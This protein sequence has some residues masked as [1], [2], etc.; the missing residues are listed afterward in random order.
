MN[1]PFDEA[2]VRHLLEVADQAARTGAGVVARAFNRPRTG[3]RAKGAGDYVTSVDRDSE[4]AIRAHLAKAVPNVA[5]VA[6]EG[7]GERGDLYWAVDPLDGTTN[8][9]IGFPAVAVAVALVSG[10][11]VMV[12]AV[13]APLLDLQFTAARGLGAWSGSS[14]LRVSERPPERAILAMALPFR[15]RE[16]T[17]RYTR[18]LETVFAATEDVR[19]VGVAELDLAWTAAG[20]FDGYFEL[21]L[22]VWDV[23][24]GSLLVEEAG[25]RVTDWD[26]GSDY[27]RSGD[28]LAGSPQT[29]ALLL[30]RA[31]ET[32]QG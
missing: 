25:G 23:A 31:R 18:M 8:F 19:R 16:L 7:G 9:L 15:R 21:G 11:R 20:V 26:G 17:A 28:V 29:H 22:G 14:R 4:D 27:L 13:R 32:S 1:V 12:G 24:A 6:E 3:A 2:E 30:D 10:N 5:V